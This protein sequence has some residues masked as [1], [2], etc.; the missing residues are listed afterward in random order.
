[1]LAKVYLYQKNYQKAY[2][3]TSD[4]M[5]KGVLR[6]STPTTPTSGARWAQQQLGVDF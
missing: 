4:V 6:R 3:L 1:M 5:A 2:D